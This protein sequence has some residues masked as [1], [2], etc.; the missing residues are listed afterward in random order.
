M[1]RY[2]AR[3]LRTE[4]D[5][6]ARTSVLERSPSVDPKAKPCRICLDYIAKSDDVSS[7]VCKSRLC[8][9]CMKG[10][11]NLTFNRPPHRLMCTVCKKVYKL[12]KVEKPEQMNLGQ[13]LYLCSLLGPS[14]YCHEI[15]DARYIVAYTLWSC[16]GLFLLTCGH[17]LEL[18][19]TDF[20]EFPMLMFASDIALCVMLQFMDLSTRNWYRFIHLTRGSY[21]TAVLFIY[22]ERSL[23]GVI[24]TVIL[25]T[26]MLMYLAV[27]IRRDVQWYR[28][29]PQKILVTING[30]VPYVIDPDSRQARFLELEPL[31]PADLEVVGEM[32]GLF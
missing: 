1:L 13:W 19:R 28:H 17:H 15:P 22:R 21:A 30:H 4:I 8:E 5:S 16:V 11:L 20:Y 7:C 25:I 29:F 24:L 31:S 3:R 18:C 6:G 23:S 14:R 26:D 2:A 32:Y 9:A 27:S 10:E 12:D